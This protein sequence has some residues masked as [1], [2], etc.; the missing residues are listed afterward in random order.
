MTKPLKMTKKVR[1]AAES[2]A[3]RY[4]VYRDIL[5]EIDASG[6]TEKGAYDESYELARSMVN[7]TSML[8]DAQTAMGIEMVP[9]G[10]LRRQHAEACASSP[11][12][13]AIRPLEI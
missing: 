5:A 8:L 6:F 2:L 10:T 1:S 13:A 4:S 12:F 3:L 7:W 11:V 9:R